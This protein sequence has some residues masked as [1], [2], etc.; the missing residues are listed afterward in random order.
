MISPLSGP[1]YFNAGSPSSILF[2]VCPLSNL[3]FKARLT[4]A[5]HLPLP[6]TAG[7]SQQSQRRG[8]T[9]VLVSMYVLTVTY[10]MSYYLLQQF[11]KFQL[12]YMSFSAY[13]HIILGIL[14]S[15]V[16]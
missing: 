7:L 3:Q 9:T 1:G 5:Y 2:F 12:V 8:V 4:A 11:R 6:V 14:M 10:Y 16:L 13:R 15:I